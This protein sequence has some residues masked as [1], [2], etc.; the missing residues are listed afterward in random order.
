MLEASNSVSH[1]GAARKA[2]T[3]SAKPSQNQA[4]PADVL[5]AADQLQET[6]Q[7]SLASRSSQRWIA[8]EMP[9]GIRR[10]MISAASSRATV[11]R[12]APTR[13]PTG[14]LTSESSRLELE[15]AGDHVGGTADHDGDER[16]R[17]ELLA[18]ERL[19]RGGRRQQRA[20]H[21]GEPGAEAEG[22]HVDPVGV[23]AERA[24][25]GRV[26]HRRAGLQAELG[27]V[28][29]P[30]QRLTISSAHSTIMPTQ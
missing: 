7:R 16:R 19:D 22:Q 23:D 27:A 21:A 3:T 4:A 8:A 13:K 24:R 15:R 29:E 12:K 20:R 28:V 17:H 6:H 14:V 1:S 26:L 11:P 2:A 5:V 25:H 30:P 18:H 10:M 9:S